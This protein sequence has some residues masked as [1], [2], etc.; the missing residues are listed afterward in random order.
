MACV[1][2]GICAKSRIQIVIDENCIGFKRGKICFATI[3]TNSRD[4]IR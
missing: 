4:R 2:R 3:G 1:R